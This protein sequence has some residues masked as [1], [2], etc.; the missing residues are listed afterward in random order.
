MGRTGV[1]RADKN[2]ISYLEMKKENYQR[3][4]NKK[5][6]MSEFT[7]IYPNLN[8]GNRIIFANKKRGLVHL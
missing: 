6:T 4:V 1:L 7:R 8:T 5:I 2:F 3:D